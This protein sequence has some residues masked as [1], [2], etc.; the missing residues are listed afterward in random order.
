M[1]PSACDHLGRQNISTAI[2]PSDIYSTVHSH[3]DLL[4]PHLAVDMCQR[5]IGLCISQ[6]LARI[7]GACVSSNCFLG[8]TCSGCTRASSSAS[9]MMWKEVFQLAYDVE[10]GLMTWVKE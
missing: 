9:H 2:W 3:L 10:D 6:V 7:G 5:C 4:A 1:V 8:W